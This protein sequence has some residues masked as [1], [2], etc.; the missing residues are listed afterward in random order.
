MF[1]YHYCMI[2][3]TP[4]PDAPHSSAQL[5]SA[6]A[7]APWLD[8]AGITVS[9]VCAVHCAASALFLA[10][11]ALVGVTR[12][13]PPWLEWGFLATSLVIGTIAL[14]RGRRWHGRRR[15]IHLLTAGVVMLLLTRATGLASSPLEPMIVLFAA[16]CIVAAHA[17]NWRYGRSCVSSEHTGPSR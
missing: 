12:A 3:S 16:S 1:G 13:L 5:R 8:A 2:V 7:G 4:L 15:P 6:T 9:V 14:R 10:A 11:L 17:L